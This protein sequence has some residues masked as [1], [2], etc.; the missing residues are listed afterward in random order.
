VVSNE[1]RVDPDETHPKIRRVL[2]K[3]EELRVFMTTVGD[4]L[5]TWF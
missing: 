3:L 5:P 1:N 4:D 2:E